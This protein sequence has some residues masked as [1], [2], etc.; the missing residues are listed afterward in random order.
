MAA[1]NGG[2]TSEPVATEEQQF[3]ESLK[4]LHR[5]RRIVMTDIPTV[6]GVEINV[7]A[8]YKEVTRQGGLVIVTAQ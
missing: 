4:E 6:N 8:L 1:E 7:Y 5:E 2:N 3:M